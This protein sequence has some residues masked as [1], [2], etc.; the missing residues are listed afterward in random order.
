MRVKGT[1]ANTILQGKIERKGSRGQ[2]DNDRKGI[3]RTEIW[4]ERSVVSASNGLN[5]RDSR[6]YTCQAAFLNTT[7]INIGYARCY[8]SVSLSN[9]KP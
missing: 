7:A 8:Y 9:M 3:N 1:M 4:R 5:S 2:Q 6:S